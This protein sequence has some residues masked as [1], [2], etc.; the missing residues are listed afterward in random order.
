MQIRFE[1]YLSRQTQIS[2]LITSFLILIV[3]V[4][5]LLGIKHSLYLYLF[6][7]G[8]LLSFLLFRT[9]NTGSAFH[10]L[11]GLFW[12]SAVLILTSAL[13]SKLG[14][15]LQ[16]WVLIIPALLLLLLLLR[17]NHPL[18]FDIRT[19]TTEE[20]ILFGFAIIS[21]ISHVVSIKG[22]LAP[23]LHDP[24]QHATWAKQIFNTGKI[25][26]FYSPGL[27]II[28]AF[29]MMVDNISV[30]TYVL[31]LT[32]L[33]NGLM[34]I[35]AYYYLNFHF[36]NKYISL[37][38]A[39]LFLIGHFPTNLFFTAG[40][41]ALLVASSFLLLLLAL[42]KLEMGKWTKLIV[43]NFL[44]FVLI[45]THYPL[46]AIGLALI[47]GII[48]LEKKFKDILLV[49]GGSILG[50]LWG[51]QKYHYQISSQQTSMFTYVE[52]IPLTISGLANFLSSAFVNFR[53]YF[54]SSYNLTLFYLGL[55]GFLLIG[56]LSLRQRQLRGFLGFIGV[57]SLLAIALNSISFLRNSVYIIYMTQQNMF[58][59][60][61]Y[62]SIAIC[63]GLVVDHLSSVKAGWRIDLIVLTILVGVVITVNI[64][65][66][67]VYRKVQTNLNLVSA[68]D[69]AA[70]QWIE[71]NIDEQDIILNNAAQNNRAEIVYGSEGGTWIPVFANR[72]EAM[73]FTEISDSKT[74]EI[75]YYNQKILEDSKDSSNYEALLDRGVEY[76]YQD[77]QGV[78]GPQIVGSRNPENFQP[79]YDESG[80]VIYQIQGCK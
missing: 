17:T 57:F 27:H 39:S 67:K 33:F 12:G 45:L 15:A 71:K 75:Y 50:I 1:V 40:K 21:F 8:A 16:K 35:P 34:F 13:L 77:S 11:T 59:I 5:T 74:H 46:A 2:K 54:A 26:Y 30:A 49:I 70:Y 38:G 65:T 62:V 69:I 3:T 52:P 66:Y 64:N 18:E 53:L 19:F 25:D 43:I 44:V 58:A 51:F 79:I 56:V 68:N 6:T 73:P 32:N 9:T 4:S 31:R 14:F 24:I 61:I 36:K 72:Q 7:T 20:L 23:I 42:F 10:L 55:F 29:G 63:G 37:I 47:G 41:N 60:F 78:F 48:V 28:S 22:F 80:V 76:Y